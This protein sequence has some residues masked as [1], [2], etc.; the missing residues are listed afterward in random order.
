M[1]GDCMALVYEY[2]QE[3][4][5]QDKLREFIPFADNGKP[6]TWKQRLRI[7]HESAQG[8]E[9][10][11]KACSPPLIHR[12]VKTNNILLSA[13]LEAK[14]ADFG[15]S[16]AF[17]NASSHVSTAVVGT[18]GYLDPEYYQSYQLS[19]KSDVFSFGVVLLEIITGK[20]PI[21]A[22]PEGG[23]LAKWVNQK[24]SRGDIESIVDP[25]MHGQYDINSVWKVTELAR[26]CTELSSAQRPTMSVTVA[27]LK[28]SLDLEISTEGTRGGRT[29]NMNPH[30]H[31]YSRNDNF[32]S[33]VSQNSVFEMGYMDGMTAPGPAAR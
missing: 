11:H 7:G 2:M 31:N 29:T 26:K 25:R 3:G 17:N 23:H 24:L 14:I 30:P 5:L 8:L 33:D 18:P 12:D 19:E 1:D 28:E 10:L 13:N 21:I 22:G 32:I 4:T 9:Y 27:E 16:R 15:L 20:P 6:L